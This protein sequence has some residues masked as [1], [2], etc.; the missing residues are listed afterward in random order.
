MMNDVAS[1]VL[2]AQTTSKPALGE[3]QFWE[4][5]RLASLFLQH[6]HQHKRVAALQAVCS[7]ERGL[8]SELPVVTPSI[9]FDYFIIPAIT[10]SAPDIILSISRDSLENS[11]AIT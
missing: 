11:K 8:S 3:I 5:S 4:G 10:T 2:D 6:Q 7:E 1:F 9:F